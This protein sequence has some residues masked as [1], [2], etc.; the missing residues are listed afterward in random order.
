MTLGGWDTRWLYF[1]LLLV[2][3]L[4]RGFEQWIAGRNM[5]RLR[6]RGGREVGRSHYPWMV[7]LHA[8][9]LLA[10]PLEVVLL[11]RPFWP[12]LGLAMLLV[13]GATLAVRYWVITTL[14]ERWTTR[15]FVVPG[16]PRITAGPYRFLRHPNYLA[17]IFEV[18]ALPL[19]HGAW[20]S[21]MVFTM[22]NA[23]LLRVRIRVENAALDLALSRRSW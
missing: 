11:E 22:L 12:P 15:V 6:A 17:V 5:R 4:E 16:A 20:L 19:V 21:A 7:L 3:I 23:W 8:A 10:C 18:A 13:L 2:V 1:G 14:G 9:F